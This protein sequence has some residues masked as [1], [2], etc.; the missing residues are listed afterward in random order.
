MLFLCEECGQV[1][2]PREFV[3][4]ARCERTLARAQGPLTRTT[5]LTG[6][7]QFPTM[8]NRALIGVGR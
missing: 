2:G 1:L 3:L 6:G 4:C 7:R 5:V 8:T